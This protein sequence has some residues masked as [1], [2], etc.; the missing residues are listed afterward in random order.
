[1]ALAGDIAS[2]AIAF[3]LGFAAFYLR[4]TQSAKWVWIAGLCQF[5]WASDI[6]L[7]HTS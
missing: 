6:H 5:G 3:I 7:V 2:A 4:K 1:M